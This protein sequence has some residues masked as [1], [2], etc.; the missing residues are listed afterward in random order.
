MSTSEQSDVQTSQAGHDP[1]RKVGEPRKNINKEKFKGRE[2][3]RQRR[4][5]QASPL[6]VSKN[7][8]NMKKQTSKVRTT[9]SK[10]RKP[11]TRFLSKI[12]RNVKEYRKEKNQQKKPKIA[13][14][15]PGEKE[16]RMSHKH[17]ERSTMSRED[18][19]L[20]V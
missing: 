8:E 11:C 7:L 19:Y 10:S 1:I 12:Y 6:E 18:Y 15:L 3:C 5:S 20:G 14:V 4:K 16:P 17:R 13:G 9:L 2:Q